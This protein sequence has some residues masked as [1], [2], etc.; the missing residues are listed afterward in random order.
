VTLLP[1]PAS[2]TE[3]FNVKEEKLK[4]KMSDH[5]YSEKEFC[6]VSKAVEKM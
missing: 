4:T 2:D 5:N 3:Y 6:Y 1:V